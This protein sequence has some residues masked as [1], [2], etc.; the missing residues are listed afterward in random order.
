[1]AVRLN[2]A[3]EKSFGKEEI[4]DRYERYDKLLGKG[5]YK[6]VYWGY[7]TQKG[8]DVA[9]NVVDLDSIPSQS[10][11]DSVNCEI[12][13][14]EKLKHPLMIHTTILGMLFE[15]LLGA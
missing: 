9:W 3:V 1:M 5:A 12:A 8:I 2:D 7:D 13:T 4:N 15:R 14:L 11:R 6:Y 10:D